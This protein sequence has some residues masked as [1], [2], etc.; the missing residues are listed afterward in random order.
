M[1]HGKVK[2]QTWWQFARIYVHKL[3]SLARVTLYINKS[4]RCEIKALPTAESFYQNAPWL[5]WP[6]RCPGFAHVGD[7]KIPPLMFWVV[8]GERCSISRLLHSWF[9]NDGAKIDSMC[10][11][12]TIGMQVSVKRSKQIFLHTVVRRFNNE[13]HRVMQPRQLGV[14]IK[15]AIIIR[16]KEKKRA[17]LGGLCFRKMLAF[18]CQRQFSSTVD[19]MRQY[20]NTGQWIVADVTKPQVSKKNQQ[21]TNL[22]AFWTW[23]LTDN[24]LVERATPRKPQIESFSTHL[25]GT[26]ATPW[27]A[28]SIHCVGGAPGW[29]LICEMYRGRRKWPFALNNKLLCKCIC[30]R[31]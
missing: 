26:Y 9:R 28:D 20:G 4:C 15:L 1:S 6:R 17:P 3:F 21:Q 8:A 10:P 24:P 30:V 7:R 11:N 25:L 16:H 23:A 22:R 31:R 27:R 5:L 18:C 2:T 29:I 12:C 13:N 14:L 19:N